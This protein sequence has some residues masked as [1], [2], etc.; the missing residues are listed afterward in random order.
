MEAGYLK[1][2][3][4]ADDLSLPLSRDPLF[5]GSMRT[6]E[7]RRTS[8]PMIAWWSMYFRSITATATSNSRPAMTIRGSMKRI[9]AH[10]EWRANIHLGAK[11]VAIDLDD[12]TKDVAVRAWR[13]SSGSRSA[14]W[15]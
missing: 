5:D 7:S 10:N 4:C 14:G 12:H 3:R 11:G 9:A 6:P 8:I 1:V 13:R 2:Y 15:T